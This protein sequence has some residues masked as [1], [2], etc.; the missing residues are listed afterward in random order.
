MDGLSADLGD[1]PI[2]PQRSSR[3][4]DQPAHPTTIPIFM[5]RCDHQSWRLER[6]EKARVNQRKTTLQNRRLPTLTIFV[7]LGATVQ[8]L[9]VIFSPS[10]LTAD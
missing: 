1:Q 7:P 10:I 5:L 8:P 2:R 6:Q 4:E 3:R 9:S